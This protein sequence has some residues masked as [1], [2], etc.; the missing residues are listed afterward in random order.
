MI[1]RGW[2]DICAALGGMSDDTA[3]RLMREDGLPVTMVCGQ[4]MSTSA[5]LATW[6]RKRCQEHTWPAAAEARP[7]RAG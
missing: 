2:K 1:Y 3:R 5:L 4:P 7:V 6:V